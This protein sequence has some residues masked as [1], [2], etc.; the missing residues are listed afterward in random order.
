MVELLLL[1]F[2]LGAIA[3]GMKIKETEQFG[4]YVKILTKGP[5]SI[6][7]VSTG[8]TIIDI[9]PTQEKEDPK[10]EGKE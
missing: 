4:E 9:A 3:F 8:E 2:L 7:E 6:Y 5:I 1:W 10:S